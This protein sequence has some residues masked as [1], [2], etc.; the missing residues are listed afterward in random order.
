MSEET[1]K[2]TDLRVKYERQI[3]DAFDLHTEERDRANEDARFCNVDGGMWESWLTETH[4]IDTNRAKLEF[5]ITTDYVN[6]Y[7]GEQKLNRANVL[8]T[9]DDNAT[10]DDDAD[11]ITGIYRAD[12]KDNDGQLAQDN[13]IEEVA[14]TGIGH[15]KLKA[16]FEDEGDPEN[17]NQDVHWEPIYNSFNTVV[18]DPQAKRIDKED[19]K[20]CAVL[21]SY[22]KESFEDAWPGAIPV[23][24]YQPH[25]RKTLDW[26][27]YDVIYVA[28][29]YTIKEKNQKVHVYQHVE[30]ELIKAYNIEDL[31]DI[32]DEL[33]EDGWEF[34]RERTV[35]QNVVEKGIFTCQEWLEKPERIAGQYIPIVPLYGFRKYVDE[36]E[37]YRGL[38]RKLKD[39]NRLFN[40]SVSRIAEASASSPDEVPILTAK[41]VKGYTDIWADKTSGAF[42]VLNDFEDAQGNPILAGPVGYLKP[43]AIDPNTIAAIETTSQFVQQTTGNAPQDTIDPDASGKAI[44]ALRARENLNTQ[45]MTDNILVGIKHSGKV[46]LSIANEIYQGLRTK[47]KADEDGSQ[48]LQQLGQ[49]IIDNETGN[50]VLANNITD[51]RFKVDVEVGPQYESQ[52]EATV[53]TLERAMTLVGPESKYFEPL[54]AMWMQNIAGTGLNELK[55]FNRNEMLKMGLAKPENEEEE[56]MLQQLAQQTDP[57]EELNQS[58][59]AQQQAEARSLDASAQ[60][61]LADTQKKKAETVKILDEIGKDPDGVTRLKFNEQTGQLESANRG[62]VP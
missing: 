51:K 52:R 31:K 18:W 13:A 22:T 25:T 53:E 39:A 8:F 7:V 19:A 47:R 1:E 50:V 23:S 10:D 49:E 59:A 30:R 43:P 27:G 55:E 40:T 26:S 9:P 2:E 16:K 33:T 32:K 5:D 14:E 3:S 60:Q 35:K 45:T 29:I 38:V 12:F 28:E 42:K 54:M 36:K 34:V 44:N 58:I 61:K 20:W 37:R 57:Q 48:S 15:F 17:D 24:G 6:R 56:A 41:Q 62:R 4:G 46:Y 21:T 11:L